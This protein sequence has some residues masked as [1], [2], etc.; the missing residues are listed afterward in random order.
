MRPAGKWSSAFFTLLQLCHSSRPGVQTQLLRGQLIRVSRQGCL[1][2]ECGA[3]HQA[4]FLGK[5]YG[6]LS[7]EGRVRDALPQRINSN[8]N[9]KESPLVTSY[10]SSQP[11]KHLDCYYQQKVL[12]IK[13]TDEYQQ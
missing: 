3:A 8:S 7:A 11:G 12:L 13:D 6:G 10:S 1:E 2:H 5:A 9:S 4:G